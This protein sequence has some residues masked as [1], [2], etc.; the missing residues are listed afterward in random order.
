MTCHIDTGT[1]LTSYHWYDQSFVLIRVVI[2]G[3]DGPQEIKLR[4]AAVTPQIF[5]SSNQKLLGV[6]TFILKTKR[7]KTSL[8]SALKYF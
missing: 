3:L 4:M 5:R 6:P 2:K 8:K 7:D 1:C